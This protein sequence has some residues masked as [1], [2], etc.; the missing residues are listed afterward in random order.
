LPSVIYFLA[1][2]VRSYN[3]V[4]GVIV[5]YCVGG[6]PVLAHLLDEYSRARTLRQPQ[7]PITGDTAAA[8]ARSDA[9]RAELRV[10]SEQSD[11]VVAVRCLVATVAGANHAPRAQEML[12]VHLKNA[13][14]R[15]AQL[16]IKQQK[17]A[18][19]SS[20]ASLL[21]VARESCPS[22]LHAAQQPIERSTVSSIQNN[23][24]L[25]HIYRK[26]LCQDLARV[27]LYVDLADTDAMQCINVVLK[28]L[29]D[30]TRLINATALSASTT[31]V[32][33]V[34][35]D[36]TAR[37]VSLRT[38]NEPVVTPSNPAVSSQLAAVTAEVT[39]DIQV[40]LCAGHRTL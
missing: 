38:A 14:R 3:A 40:S 36:R 5:D 19:I 24:I 33:S 9:L 18:Q 1:E 2:L 8:K 35:V 21:S 28:T 39:E 25:R 34:A 16:T 32:S 11:C 4:A 15:A 27:P 29:E 6:Q 10:L 26:G 23:T 31:T 37:A 7:P 12:V 30:L 22:M 13:L 20:V 17:Y